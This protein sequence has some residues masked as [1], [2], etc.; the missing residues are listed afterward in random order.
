MWFKKKAN[1][2]GFNANTAVDGTDW[3]TTDNVQHWSVS[4]TLPS[5]ADASNYFYLPALGYYVNGRLGF[6]GGSGYYWS[7]SAHPL[8]GSSAYYLYIISGDI[9]VDSQARLYGYRIGSFE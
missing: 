9:L 6:I 4:F 2:S 8:Y 7:S 1:I 3:R 5:A